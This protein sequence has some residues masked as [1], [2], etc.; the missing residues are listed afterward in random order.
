MKNAFASKISY[1]ILMFLFLIIIASFLFSGFD[2][3]R[4]GSASDVASVD[5]TPVTLKEY[6]NALSRQVEFF[7]QMMGGNGLSQKQL[8]EMGIKDSVMSGLVQQ[9]LILNAAKK[10]GIVVSMDEVRSEIRNMPYFKNQAGQ[11]DVNQYR[12]A[13]Q[14]NGYT[15]T[16]FEELIKSDLKQKKMD[17]LFDT[18][19]LS[20]AF[21]K[22]VAEFKNESVTIHAVK[23]PRQSLSPLIS[24]SKEE[25]QAYLAKPE[26]EKAIQDAYTDNASEYNKPEEVK[27]RHILIKGDD[28]KALAKITSLKKKVSPANF[29]K[30][31]SQETEDATGTGNGGELGW[32]S[33]GRMVPEFEDVAF[34]M[35]KGQISEPVKTQFGYHLIYVEDKK[36]A[37]VTPLSEVKEELAQLAIQRTKP[38]DL[39]NLLKNQEERLKKALESNNLSEIEALTAKVEGTFSK[40]VKVNKFDQNIEGQS[41]GTQEAEKVFN[42]ANGEVI[43]LGNAGS[44]YLVKVISRTE[45]SSAPTEEELKKEKAALTQSYSRKVREEL[46]KKLNNNAK[47]VTNRSLM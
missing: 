28:D 36:A 3:F 9:K 37:K 45:K 18:T 22:D 25:I 15:P 7:N 14:V 17:S 2:N 32:F 30:I 21:A 27:A 43:S 33:R 29:A 23:I 35:N 4:L 6:Q 34:K 42:A 46:L 13:L 38:Q 24:I 16:Q 19:L 41:L 8:E 1:F 40:S 11:F 39:D 10:A 5:G 44:I 26:N 20:D 12:N 47:V 31:A